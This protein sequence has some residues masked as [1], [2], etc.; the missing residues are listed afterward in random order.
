[1][2]K[3]YLLLTVAVLSMTIIFSCRKDDSIGP[4]AIPERDRGEEATFA[5]GEIETFLET[6]FYNYE[7][8]QNPPAGFDFK[9]RFDTIA[10]DNAD[11]TPL[12]SQVSFKMV[13]DRIEEDVIYK[14]YY[15]MVDEGEGEEVTF[16]DTVTMTYEGSYIVG[17][18][19]DDSDPD[20]DTFSY[21][22]VFETQNVSLRLDLTGTINGFQDGL[23]EFNGATDVITNPDGTLSFEGFGIGA[24]FIPSGLGYFIMPPPSGE[25]PVYAQLIFTF[26]VYDA[27]V[28]DQDNDGII[29]ILEDL[30]GNGIE[31]DDDSDQDG[32]FNLF[33]PDDDDDGRL[34]RDEIEIDNDGNVTFPDVDGDGTPDYLDPDS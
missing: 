26:Q 14:L 18:D 10:G 5:Q 12:T 7:E 11:K 1:M 15:L 17:V 4:D 20:N 34:T 8:F 25:I 27:E 19:A 6:H 9:I 13:P 21:N 16:P 29:S 3:G 30:N 22:E 24:V 23:I 33:D 32:A 28:G 2:K 31:E